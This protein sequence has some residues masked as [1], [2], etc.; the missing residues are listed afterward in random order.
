MAES[1]PPAPAAAVAAA[2]AAPG[3]WG[4]LLEA[5]HAVLRTPELPAKARAPAAPHRTHSH[6]HC[7]PP[8]PSR[9]FGAGATRPLEGPPPATLGGVPSRPPP[10]P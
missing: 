5:A 10:P 1:A 9:T 6:S 8:L 7:L 2:T 3:G 4:T